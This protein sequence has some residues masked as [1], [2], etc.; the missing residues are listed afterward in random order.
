M[1]LCGHFRTWYPVAQRKNYMTR[2]LPVPPLVP[3]D[4]TV[5]AIKAARRGELVTVGST[6]NLVASLNAG[7]KK[8]RSS[9]ESGDPGWKIADSVTLAL[10]SGKSVFT[11]IRF[12]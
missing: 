8:P 6:D 11:Q 12:S 1:K 4:E 7:D 10:D 9:R 5:V 2:I 3:N